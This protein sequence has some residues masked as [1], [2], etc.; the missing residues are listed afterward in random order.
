[1]NMAESKPRPLPKPRVRHKSTPVSTNQSSNVTPNISC[2]APVSKPP[3]TKRKPVGY[4][5]LDFNNK[6]LVSIKADIDIGDDS[7]ANL[8]NNASRK[9]NEDFERNNNVANFKNGNGKSLIGNGLK[10]DTKA[11]IFSKTKTV[12]LSIF[13]MANR[14]FQKI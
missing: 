3:V 8:E 12:V 9:M 13:T 10:V 5:Q 7:S 11:S 1:M 14:Q 4:K 6:G 2:S